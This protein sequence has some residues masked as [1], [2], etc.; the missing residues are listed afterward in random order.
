MRGAHQTAWIMQAIQ[1]EKQK[2]FL[3]FLHLVTPFSNLFLPLIS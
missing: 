1:H 3:L 2:V